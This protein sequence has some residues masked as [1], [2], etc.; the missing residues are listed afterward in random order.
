MTDLTA[1]ILDFGGDPAALRLL[2]G[3]GPELLP[4]A[5]LLT[6]R[7]NSRDILGAVSGVY[8]W[9]GA[10][11]DADKAAMQQALEAYCDTLI[12]FTS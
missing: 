9:Q 12:E 10:P 8:E 1:S 7:R 5:T 2:D 6:A 4:Y 3:E 11:T